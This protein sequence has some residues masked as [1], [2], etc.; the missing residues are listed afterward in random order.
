[1]ERGESGYT[2][3][4]QLFFDEEYVPF[5]HA[6]APIMPR[7][8]GT[9][10]LPITKTSLGYD[11]DIENIDYNWS[12]SPLPS[13]WDMLPLDSTPSKEDIDLF[14]KSLE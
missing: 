7:A 13:T 4:W 11:V 5:L 12:P 9:F 6:D 1:M 2:T 8:E 14:I 3:P 10:R